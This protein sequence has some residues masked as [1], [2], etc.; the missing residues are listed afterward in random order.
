MGLYKVGVSRRGG[1]SIEGVWVY[2]CVSLQGGCVCVSIKDVCKCVSIQGVCVY[3][4][5]DVYKVC[6][7][8]YM[9]VYTRGLCMCV[10]QRVCV[11][12]QDASV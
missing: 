4:R 11:S 10:Y 8:M 9:C 12:I 6:G 1:V 3:E 5:R 2:V 7:C